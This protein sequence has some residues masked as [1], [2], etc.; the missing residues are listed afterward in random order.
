MRHKKYFPDCMWQHGSLIHSVSANQ[1]LNPVWEVSQLSS[2]ETIDTIF[3]GIW[4]QRAVIVTK[5]NQASWK[6]S[7]LLSDDDFQSS[8][9]ASDCKVDRIVNALDAMALT[10]IT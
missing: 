7:S 1:P 5:I 2:I 10:Y 9:E 4:Y 3:S 6:I 8:R